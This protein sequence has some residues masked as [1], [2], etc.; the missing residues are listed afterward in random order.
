VLGYSRD[1]VDIF[2]DVVSV[3]RAK[4]NEGAHEAVT[5]VAEN[6]SLEIPSGTRLFPVVNSVDSVDEVI[7]A[8]RHRSYG[9]GIGVWD[10]SE[11]TRKRMLLGLL[12]AGPKTRRA[13]S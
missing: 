3:S 13:T 9:T 10:S 5:A 2:I 7:S 4:K 12:L 8:S 11:G 6:V 1:K